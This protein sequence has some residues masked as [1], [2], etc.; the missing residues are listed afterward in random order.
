MH[1]YV[2]ASNSRKLLARLG[3]FTPR[4]GLLARSGV[5]TPSREGLTDDMIW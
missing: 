4:R 2:V 5:F 3:V 1:K